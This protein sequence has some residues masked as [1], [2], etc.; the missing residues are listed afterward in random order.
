[1]GYEISTIHTYIISVTHAPTG[2]GGG[3]ILGCYCES[4]CGNEVEN[5]DDQKKRCG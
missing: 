3:D 1:M 5:L 4:V 2:A